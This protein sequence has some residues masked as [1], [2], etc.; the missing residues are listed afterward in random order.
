[1]SRRA[2]G[3]LSCGPTT[4]GPGRD[5]SFLGQSSGEILLPCGRGNTE[6]E[7]GRIRTPAHG[8]RRRARSPRGRFRSGSGCPNQ[9][10]ADNLLEFVIHASLP[11]RIGSA[12]LEARD[13]PGASGVRPARNRPAADLDRPQ[14]PLRKPGPFRPWMYLLGSLAPL[15][16]PG[17]GRPPVPGMNSPFRD[18]PLPRVQL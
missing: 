6:L 8:P 14:W 2:G 16:L 13:D 7:A 4:R 12:H 11:R 15:I 10:G 5:R 9:H 3:Y 17:R 18:A 1:M